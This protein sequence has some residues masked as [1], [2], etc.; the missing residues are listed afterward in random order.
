MSFTDSLNN[1][2]QEGCPLV[3]H[4]IIQDIKCPSSTHE[5]ILGMVPFIDPL[6]Y[7]LQGHKMSFID[8]P[9]STRQEGCPLLTHNIVLYKDIKCS[10]STH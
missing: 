4:Y 1:T 8:S 7:T 10:S 3:A 5:T 6:Y 9:N 2:R